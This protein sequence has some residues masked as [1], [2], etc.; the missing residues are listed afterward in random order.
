[1]KRL[2]PLALCSAALFTADVSSAQPEVPSKA[3][4]AKVKG[5]MK[6]FEAELRKA[7]RQV[8]EEDMKAQ[9]R[10]RAEDAKN[11]AKKPKTDKMLKKAKAEMSKGMAKGKAKARADNA[12]PKTDEEREARRAQILATAKARKGTRDARKKELRQRGKARLAGVKGDAKAKAAQELRHHARRVARLERIAVLAAEAKD[13]KAADRVVALM[14]KE[15][16]RHQ[17]KMARLT[18]APAAADATEEA[19]EATE[20]ETKE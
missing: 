9:K 12:G 5:K 20:E 17:A 1:M 7:E 13:E 4:R 18:E 10:A 16:Q 14:T 15:N 11:A 3:D 2:L 6:G 8:L 19:D